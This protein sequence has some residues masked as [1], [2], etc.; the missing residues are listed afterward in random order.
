MV[1]NCDSVILI[2]WLDHSGLF[3]TRAETRWK[4]M[5]SSGDQLAYTDLTRLE[6]RV[7]PLKRKDPIGLANFDRFFA[8]TDLVFLPLTS[9][10]FDRAA[11]LRSDFG[12]KTP[13]ALHLAAAIEGGCSL[14]LTND[15]RYSR[16]PLIPVEILA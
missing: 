16:C 14:F 2:Y 7:G 3:Q 5:F 12:L 10:V 4:S 13:D 9:P 15:A 8:R 1:V 11:L 6:C